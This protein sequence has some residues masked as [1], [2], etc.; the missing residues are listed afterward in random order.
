MVLRGNNA[1][2]QKTVHSSAAYYVHALLNIAA[3]H[4]FASQLS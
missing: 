4:D 3:K 1:L 2:K